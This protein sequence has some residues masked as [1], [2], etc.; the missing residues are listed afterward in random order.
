LTAE[1]KK[2]NHHHPFPLEGGETLTQLEVAYHT[3]G[4]L[5]AERDN[6][7]W[8]FHALT[9]NSDAADWWAGLV[10]A[11]RLF[12]PERYFIV[13]ANILGS[14]YGSS[15][16]LSLNPLTGKPWYSDFPMITTRDMVR[17]HQL[18][19]EHLG[20]RRIFLGLG[21]SIGGQQAVEWA[22]TEPELFR[23]IALIATNAR[24]SA[25]G[26]AFNETQRMAI[27]CDPTWRDHDP[28]AGK[29]GLMA[30][31]ANAILS[32][33]NYPTFEKTQTDETGKLDNFRASS[34]QNYQGLKLA[35]RFNTYSY[36]LLTKSMDSHD[37]GRHRGSTALALGNIQADTL[38]VGIS[39]DI[40]F[41][42]SEQ[43][44]LAAN[45]PNAVY[46]EID[47][48]YGHDGFLIEFEQL[49]EII[50][51]FLSTVNA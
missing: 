9:A 23:H 19:R 27:S 38:V 24:H 40:L 50:K 35:R 34:Y 15:G 11:G 28:E 7:I 16:P 14:C 2:L 46:Y 37:V 26:I 48:T 3:Y 1:V 45:I 44:F 49:T 42:I 33:R 12:D 6:V 21:G 36:W 22:I 29:K 39:S 4:N 32:Y 20:I 13:C 18:L 5:N 41:P 31:R 30:A 17:A 25:W 51:E 47:S 10:G 8:V 43:R